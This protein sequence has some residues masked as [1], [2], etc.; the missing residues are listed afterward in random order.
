MNTV[1]MIKKLEKKN[2]AAM[3]GDRNHGALMSLTELQILFAYVLD[4][5]MT[6]A[7]MKEHIASKI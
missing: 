5:T 3:N 2:I 4:G 1:D 6:P 7:E